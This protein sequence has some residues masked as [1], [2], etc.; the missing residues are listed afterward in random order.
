[1][2]QQQIEVQCH[3]MGIDVVWESLHK[4]PASDVQQV[5]LLSKKCYTLARQFAVE[6]G[7]EYVE[8]FLVLSFGLAIGHA[9]NVKQDG[10]WVDYTGSGKDGDV[11]V[12]VKRVSAD[13]FKEYMADPS[14]VKEFE[15]HT[16][17]PL[18]CALR[19]K[20]TK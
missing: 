16:E 19:S 5:P 7:H 18:S 6:N 15:L 17:L 4:L 8:G 1:M 2:A 20:I 13:I 3:A 12:I 11:Y 10:T 9:W 14:L